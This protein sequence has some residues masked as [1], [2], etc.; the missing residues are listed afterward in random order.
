MNPLTISEIWKAISGHDNYEISNFGR[1]RPC[2][3]K[4]RIMGQRV[5][6]K[7]HLYIQLRADG[8]KHKHFIHRLVACAFIPKI[9]G[10][11]IVNHID[12][13]KKNNFY[14]NLEWVTTQENTQHYHTIVKHLTANMR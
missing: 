4:R 12:G 1:V 3:D 2:R 8:I 9:E 7:G 6:Y 5:H 10:K 11:D 14:Q 13:N